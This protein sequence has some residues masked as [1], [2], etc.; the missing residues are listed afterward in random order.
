MQSDMRTPVFTQPAI[1]GAEGVRRRKV[2]LEQ[3]THRIT[4]PSE[5]RLHTHED[6]AEFRAKDL[7]T[8]A[9]G[10]LLA[11]RRTPR[12]FNLRQ[13][14][15]T[16]HMIVGRNTREHRRHRTVLLAITLNHGISQRVHR[17]RHCDGVA[18]VAHCDH[19]VVQ[20]MEAIDVRSAAGVAGIRRKIEQHHRHL[21]IGTRRSTHPDHLRHAIGHGLDT[22]HYRQRCRLLDALRGTHLARVHHWTDRTVQLRNCDLQRRLQRIQSAWIVLPLRRGLKL[23]RLQTEV[24]HIQLAERV[25]RRRRVVVR[26]STDE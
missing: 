8:V 17:L 6:V 11:R 23:E 19:R 3:Q 26:R 24:R 4:F 22:L 12:A 2:A 21:A 10:K 25:L 13:V 5:R 15:L 14:P 20:R 18:G 16:T 1:E 9:V 7:D